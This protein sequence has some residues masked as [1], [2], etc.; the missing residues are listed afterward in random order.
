MLYAAVEYDYD[1]EYL[2]RTCEYDRNWILVP[3]LV[4][5]IGLSLLAVLVS[6]ARHVP[7]NWNE[8]KYLAICVVTHIIVIAIYAPITFSTFLDISTKWLLRSLCSLILVQCILVFLFYI[9]FWIVRHG[10]ATAHRLSV[11]VHQMVQEMEASSRK[12]R[13]TTDGGKAGFDKAA[14][15]TFVAGASDADLAPLSDG[16]EED[17]IDIVGIED[18]HDDK[19][20]DNDALPK[21]GVQ[22]TAMKRTVSN[23]NQRKFIKLENNNSGQFDLDD[24]IT[25]TP[26]SPNPVNLLTPDMDTGSQ[27]AGLRIIQSHSV[28]TQRSGSPR[29]RG[30]SRRITADGDEAVMNV[31]QSTPDLAAFQSTEL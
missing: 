1:R 25:P 24:I 11:D 16:D 4:L 29:S 18:L 14:T 13:N 23:Q 31:P 26:F 8:A 30:T 21:Q 17:D 10:T 19:K 22:L 7:E 28:S 3:F 20:Q 27:F 12:G 9:K 6:R 15:D 2:Y 5:F